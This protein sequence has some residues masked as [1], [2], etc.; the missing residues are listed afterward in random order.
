MRRFLQ[1]ITGIALFLCGTGMALAQDPAAST[2]TAFPPPDADRPVGVTLDTGAEQDGYI[3]LSVIQSKDILLLSNDG[4]VVNKWG[5]D[6]YAGQSAYLLPDGN[7]LRTASLLNAFGPSG[8]WGYVSGRLE[9]Y[10]W[11]GQPV[12]SY[13]LATDTLVGHHDIYPMPNGHILMVYFEKHSV[14]EALAAGRDPALISPEN[15]LWSETLFEVDPSTHQIVWEWHAWDHLIQDYDPQMANYGMV[16]DHPERINLNYLD[17]EL[18]P[19]ADWL[20]VNKIDYNAALDQIIISTRTYSEFWVIDHDTTTEEAKGTA[21]DLLFRWGNPAAYDAGS[22]QDRPLY[23]QHDPQWIPEGYPGAGDILIFDN[24]S[25]Q[26]RYS[27]VVEVAL[28]TDDSG[29]YIMNPGEAT[30]VQTVWEYQGNPPESFYSALISGA[31]RQPNGDTLITD[32][33]NG[34]LFEVNA[35]GETVWEYNAPPAVWI[36]RGER[37]DLSKFNFDLSGD[38]GFD[39]GIVWEATCQDGAVLYL[40]QYHIT[41]GPQMQEYIDTYGDNAQSAWAGE[42]CADHGG[43]P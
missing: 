23:F 16:G 41:E 24:G 40:F 18:E 35:D 8:R 42:S 29:K 34:R 12:W 17:P 10:T 11:D 27:R 37:Y 26:R 5:S 36:F 28:P 13:E 20:H 6:Y 33:L 25:S 38:L 21:G 7:L 22:P 1:S 31:Q 9:E 15:Q 30:T 32:G 43:V 2:E 19:N 3:L 4:R 14:E 39:G